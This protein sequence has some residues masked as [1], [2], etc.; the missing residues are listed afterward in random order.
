[1][2]YKTL[3]H[4]VLL[5]M[6]RP[7]WRWNLSFQSACRCSL[8]ELLFCFVLVLAGISKFLVKT[9]H[10]LN[11][12]VRHEK[13]SLKRAKNIKPRILFLFVFPC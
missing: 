11:N 3:P 6:V 9:G 10:R 5:Q 4:A 7:D 8:A 12:D 2:E 1:M 13:E